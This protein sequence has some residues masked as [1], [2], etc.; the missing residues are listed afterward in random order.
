MFWSCSTWAWSWA[1]VEGT[2]ASPADVA[3]MLVC[4]AETVAL[5]LATVCWSVVMVC[6]STTQALEAVF[7]V[8]PTP[9]DDP[10][11]RA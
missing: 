2:T 9:A 10:T 8:S 4:W 5:S 6:W 3:A 7:T 11:T 1:T